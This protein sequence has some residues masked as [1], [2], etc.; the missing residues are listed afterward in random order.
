VLT[1]FYLGEVVPG[2]TG[3]HTL[4]GDCLWSE[5]RCMPRSLTADALFL[6]AMSRRQAQSFVQRSGARFVLASCKPHA[7]LERLLGPMI[8]AVHRFRLR[9]GLRPGGDR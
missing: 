7:N 3:R 4:V 9:G 5:P 2:R 1:Q 8:I 6:G